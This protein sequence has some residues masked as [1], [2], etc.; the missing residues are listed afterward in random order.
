MED[1][2]SSCQYYGPPTKFH[3]GRK[4]TPSKAIFS[5]TI[6][7][8]WTSH[9]VAVQCPFRGDPVLAALLIILS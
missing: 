7:G 2:I 4:G 9:K 8:G 5:N 6:V 3:E 1:F